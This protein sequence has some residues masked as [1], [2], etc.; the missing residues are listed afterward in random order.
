[1][2]LNLGS[3]IN[4]HASLNVITLDHRD[5]KFIE[6]QE[7]Y[8]ADEH[9]DFTTGIREVDNTVDEIWMGDVLEHIFKHKTQFVLNECHRV[10]VSGGKLKIS[11]PDMA[12]AMPLWLA[13]NAQMEVAPVFINGKPLFDERAVEELYDCIWGGQDRSNQVNSYYDSHF[14]GF[15]EK[16]LKKSLIKAGF[17]K[18]ER[19]SIHG[20][21]YELAIEATK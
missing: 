4:H 21:W 11:V 8:P 19:I 12:V 2:K 7:K 10:L 17:S 13:H 18:V 16:T 5:W 20:T 15:T 14:N 1:M 3:G 9:Y 6:V